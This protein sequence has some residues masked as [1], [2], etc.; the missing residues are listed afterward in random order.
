[1]ANTKK[2]FMLGLLGTIVGM[3]VRLVRGRRS[4]QVEL[5]RWEPPKES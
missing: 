5:G 2:W 1:M 4:E 3:A